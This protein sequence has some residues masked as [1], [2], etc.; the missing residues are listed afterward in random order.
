MKAI[1]NT[2]YP[3]L[4]L[5]AALDGLIVGAVIESFYKYYHHWSWGRA[6]VYAA[7]LGLPYDIERV[8]LSLHYPFVIPLLSITTFVV[9]A[10]S[11][12]YLLP[13]RFLAIVV[14]CQLVASFSVTTAAF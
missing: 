5:L 4:F 12:R 6:A 14:F 9:V 2:S 10:V 11:L 3:R 13:G 8:P 7:E 1:S